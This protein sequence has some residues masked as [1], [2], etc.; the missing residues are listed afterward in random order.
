MWL[1][2]VIIL[3]VTSGD[4]INLSQFSTNFFFLQMNFCVLGYTHTMNKKPNLEYNKD[5]AHHN[6]SLIILDQGDKWSC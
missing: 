1:L 4:V 5:S 2:C 3:C 6:I